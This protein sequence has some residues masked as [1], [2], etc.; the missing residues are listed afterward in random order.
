M[1]TE[2]RG[3]SDDAGQL[4]EDLTVKV[5]SN[6]RVLQ[7]CREL[8]A[9]EASW[10]SYRSFLLAASGLAPKVA[11]IDARRSENGDEQIPLDRLL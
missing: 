1:S 7:H 8:V 5:W 10:S 11:R 9:S 2:T 3:D 4:I 6:F